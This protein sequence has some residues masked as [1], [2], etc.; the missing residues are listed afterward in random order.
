MN[1]KKE[2]QDIAYCFNC[3]TYFEDNLKDGN[4]WTC[5]PKCKGAYRF[6][7]LQLTNDERDGLGL[8]LQD[9]MVIEFKTIKQFNRLVKV[10]RNL[11]KKSGAK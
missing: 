11:I 3:K 1:K 6:N 2:I 8:E 7:V 9:E 5:C 4:G 10:M